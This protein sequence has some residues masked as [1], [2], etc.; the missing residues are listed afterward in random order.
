MASIGF[1]AIDFNGAAVVAD[2]H[3]PSGEIYLLNTKQF[4]FF[5]H[6][7]RNMVFEGWYEFG[8]QDMMTGRILLACNLICKAPRLQ[9]KIESVT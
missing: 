3:C 7:E 9:A 6:R 5:V 1:N 2:P 4:N 8:N